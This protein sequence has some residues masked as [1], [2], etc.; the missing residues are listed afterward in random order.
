LSLVP[1]T[2]I[3]DTYE[4]LWHL[5]MGLVNWDGRDDSWVEDSFLEAAGLETFDVRMLKDP[6]LPLALS[7]FQAF[8]PIGLWHQFCLVA[9]LKG[10]NLG[11][12]LA[13]NILVRELAPA[14]S[15]GLACRL[16]NETYL[17]HPL[18][19]MAL[20]PGMI[21]TI[22]ALC[23]SERSEMREAVLSKM[24]AMHV[25]TTSMTM[26][27]QA[28]IPGVELPFGSLPDQRQNL[29]Q[30][31]EFAIRGHAW[32]AALPLIRLVRDE[33]LSEYREDEWWALLLRALAELSAF[34]PEKDAAVLE[35]IHLLVTQLLAQ[36]AERVGDETIAV[37]LRQTALQL[38]LA[39]KTT[40]TRNKPGA[41]GPATEEKVY[42]RRRISALLQ[43][44]DSLARSGSADCLTFYNEACE[45][46]SEADDNYRLG[47]AQ[48][49][50]ARA[51][52]NVEDL[53]DPV[54]YEENARL[55]LATAEAGL[56]RTRLIA[57]CKMSIGTAIVLQ[58]NSS[59]VLDPQRAEEAYACL[60]FAVASDAAEPVIKA[61]AYNSIGVLMGIVGLLDE[62]ANAYLSACKQFE[63][64]EDA[65]SLVR[66]QVNAAQVLHAVGRSGDAREIAQEAMNNL[67]RAP[68]HSA[69]LMPVIR[70]LLAE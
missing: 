59:D 66:A 57:S 35:N 28:A 52:V 9:G 37:Q 70:D 25:T 2:T 41:E 31:T 20:F 30:A 48:L 32:E 54:K 29:Y 15:C 19:S 69:Q 1:V 61:A 26:R 43:W 7:L 53:Y 11:G 34:P 21:G 47:D 24:H 4:L 65:D 13:P 50:V 58:L 17:I 33:L 39:D 23:G 38:A 27:M 18:A 46:A 45:L 67:A 68:R 16:P 64:L 22:S 62:A 6:T 63:S 8:L 42:I 44:G 3:D 40:I 36:E 12:D 14:V 49:A 10:L 60:T 5:R 55:A 56:N 51:Y